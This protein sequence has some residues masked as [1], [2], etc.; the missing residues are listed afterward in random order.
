MS[1]SSLLK[2]LVFS[3]VLPQLSNQSRLGSQYIDVLEMTVGEGPLRQHGAS[4][5]HHIIALIDIITKKTYVV[6]DESNWLPNQVHLQYVVGD[7]WHF[8]PEGFSIGSLPQG[9][10][11]PD[12]LWE[13]AHVHTEYQLCILVLRNLFLGEVSRHRP[14]FVH[15]RLR[16][17]QLYV[18]PRI[19]RLLLEGVIGVRGVLQVYGEISELELS[20]QVF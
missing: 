3:I 14:R 5:A 4:L 16:P 1:V 19:R 6:S 20:H 10:S 7:W 13:I 8:A 12:Y 15:L 11:I 9:Q 17:N 18:L 2:L